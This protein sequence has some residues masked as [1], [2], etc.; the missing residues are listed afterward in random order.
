MSISSSTQPKLHARL[1]AGRQRRKCPSV[2]FP[3]ALCIPEGKLGH[4]CKL[5]LTTWKTSAGLGGD[6]TADRPCR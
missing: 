6:C 3:A 5:K 4:P 1:A 2:L